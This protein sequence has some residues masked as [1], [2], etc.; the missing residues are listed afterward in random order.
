MPEMP[1]LLLGRRSVYLRH[2]HPLAPI[3]S[4]TINLNAWGKVM[5]VLAI[6]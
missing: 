6:T 1:G 2:K 5:D 4:L 3:Q